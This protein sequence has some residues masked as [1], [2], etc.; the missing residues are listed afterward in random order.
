[1]S[2]IDFALRAKKLDSANVIAA[3][4]RGLKPSGVW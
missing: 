2:A 1:M 4:V 3:F